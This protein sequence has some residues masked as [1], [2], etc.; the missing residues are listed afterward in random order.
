MP[1]KSQAGTFLK[2]AG[3]KTQLLP[4]LTESLRPA[5]EGKQ[6][7]TYIEPFI[8]SGAVLFEVLK[9]YPKAISRVL[10][11]DVNRDLINVWKVVRDQPEQL[12]EQLYLLRAEYLKL[13]ESQRKDYFLEI[14]KRFN[15][16]EESL[17]K[18]ASHLIFLNKTCF[19]GLY[20]VNSKNEF[21]V[22]H[23][24]YSKPA[25][26]N[27]SAIRATARLLQRVE[28]YNDDFARLLWHA[29]Q[30]QHV[31]WYF[32]P[33]YRPLS[34]S[35]SFNAYSADAFDDREQTRLKEVCDEIHRRGQK[36]VLSNSDP[37]NTRPDDHFFDNLYGDY[38]INRVQARRSI[39][40]K[41]GKRGP[42][43]ELIIRNF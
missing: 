35:S 9:T 41:G 19:N 2:W 14:R 22:P 24:R 30:T 18:Q 20:R 11:N 37:K 39:N 42:L 26:F 29:G 12:I 21:N 40:S 36:F 31:V 33:P 23:G 5:L 6:G 4:Y 32:D 17:L 1:K 15:L 34:K 16:R 43:F 7:I 8:G 25:V 27:E 13:E 28:I 38:V 10:I 3:G